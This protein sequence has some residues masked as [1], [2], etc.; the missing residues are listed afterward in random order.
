MYYDDKEIIERDGL[1]F[2]VR[3]HDDDNPDFSWMGEFTSHPKR[4][5]YYVDR[6]TGYLMGPNFI[7][8]TYT[9]KDVFV[10]GWVHVSQFFHGYDLPGSGIVCVPDD[11]AQR[12]EICE[13][14]GGEITLDGLTIELYHQEILAFDLSIA[15]DRHAY[16]YWVPGTNHLPPHP[17][18]WKGHPTTKYLKEAE[19]EGKLKKHGIA[20]VI[21][22]DH[23]PD[24][25]M[26]VLYVCEDY[27]R[28]ASYGNHWW[29]VGLEVELL[30]GDEAVESASLWGV[31]SDCG[32]EYELEII[33][34]LISE[35]KHRLPKTVKELRAKARRISK[36]IGA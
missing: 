5:D 22:K 12:I 4:D 27:E 18:N 34:E 29:S 26:D 8:E 14:R 6:K 21:T 16:E 30:D 24:F 33:D 19:K 2:R 1:R 13:K 31:E 23:P 17:D 3:F 10:L 28:H 7:T 20:P 9:A 11:V 35:I 36:M 15:Y 25:W 32:K